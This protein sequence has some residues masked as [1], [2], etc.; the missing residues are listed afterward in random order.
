M[1]AA[2]VFLLAILL[3]SCQRNQN[4]G[5]VG[6]DLY[7]HP[8]SAVPED[9]LLQ[10]AIRTRLEKEQSTAGLVHVRVAR[11]E[12]VLTGNV[13]KKEI[14]AKAE[15][16]ARGTKVA[17]NNDPVIVPGTVTNMIKVGNQ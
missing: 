9:V 15:E 2:A 4:L 11:L 12:V 8:E 17:V 3:S 1:R 6:V 10:T 5:T 7:I 13:A 16:I 14:S